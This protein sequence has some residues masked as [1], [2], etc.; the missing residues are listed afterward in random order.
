MFSSPHE[1]EIIEKLHKSVSG[2]CDLTLLS[3]REKLKEGFLR[4][5]RVVIQEAYLNDKLNS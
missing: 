5:S 2:I 3:L 4:E 1:T